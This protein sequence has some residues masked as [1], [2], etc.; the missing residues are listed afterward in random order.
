M[1]EIQNPAF[2][3]CIRKCFYSNFI[4]TEYIKIFILIYDNLL[5]NNFWWFYYSR[6]FY[7]IIFIYQTSL[8]TLYLHRFCIFFYC[9]TI[10][11]FIIYLF[12]DNIDSFILCFEYFL[13]L[14][15]HIKGVFKEWNQ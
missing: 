9:F 4:M 2:C 8:E 14:G 10:T 1:P 3:Q 11:K 6:F 15:Y 7:C 5:M 12:M 13:L